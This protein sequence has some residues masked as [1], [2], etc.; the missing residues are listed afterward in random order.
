MITMTICELAAASAMIVINIFYSSCFIVFSPTAEKY[1]ILDFVEYN[2]EA[3]QFVVIIVIIIIDGNIFVKH[4][5][6]KCRECNARDGLYGEDK[7]KDEVTQ[8]SG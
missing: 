2:H 7:A 5:S 4:N 1:S 8:D 3:Y 6:S